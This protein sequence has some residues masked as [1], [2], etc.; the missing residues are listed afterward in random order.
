MGLFGCRRR[1]GKQFIRHFTL[2]TGLQTRTLLPSHDRR[3][4]PAAKTSLRKEDGLTSADEPLLVHVCIKQRRGQQ[5]DNAEE[6]KTR[7]RNRGRRQ[8]DHDDIVVH[9]IATNSCGR[10]R[11]LLPRIKARPSILL[12][13]R[14]NLRASQAVRTSSPAKSAVS[15]QAPNPGWPL[16]SQRS[17]GL[18]RQ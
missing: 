1:K 11:E 15:V 8:Q 12:Q 6:Q 3:H 18:L 14:G 16:F 9:D 10:Y 4:L 13:C 2:K 17:S 7:E 5:I